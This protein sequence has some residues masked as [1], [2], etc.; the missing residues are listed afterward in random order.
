MFLN[1]YILL[2]KYQHN[3]FDFAS[4]NTEPKIFTIQLFTGEVYCLLLCII[5]ILFAIHYLQIHHGC[6]P[7]CLCSSYSCYLQLPLF[8]NY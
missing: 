6:T 7:S 8:H 1:S 4:W 2:Y 3:V 5:V